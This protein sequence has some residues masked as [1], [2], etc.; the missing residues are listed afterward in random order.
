M[1]HM[2]M[3]DFLKQYMYKRA[4][5]FHLVVL[6]IP[7]FHFL[8]SSYTYTV[9]LGFDIKYLLANFNIFKMFILFQNYRFAEQNENI[10]SF[11]TSC[12]SVGLVVC[13]FFIIVNRNRILSGRF[14][15]CACDVC[16]WK[17][18]RSFMKR[19]QNFIKEPLTVL[20]NS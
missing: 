2:E 13:L 16:N 5:L 1:Q 12:P 4:V 6:K 10:R 18:N 8:V 20:S 11:N 14:F 7:L 15:L 17:S 19:K 9:V 3:R